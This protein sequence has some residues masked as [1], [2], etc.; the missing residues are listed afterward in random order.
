MATLLLKA[1]HEKQH[2]VICGQKDL[3]EMLFTLRCV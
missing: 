3:M 1:I 2:S